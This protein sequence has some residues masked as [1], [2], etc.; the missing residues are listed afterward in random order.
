MITSKSEYTSGALN[1][2]T[3]ADPHSRFVQFDSSCIYDLIIEC[4]NLKDFVAD[5]SLDGL[6]VMNVYKRKQTFKLSWLRQI[7]M[8]PPNWLGGFSSFA[9]TNNVSSNFSARFS[10]FINN[11]RQSFDV[12]NSHTV[13]LEDK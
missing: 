1:N 13:S 2:L 9:A 5:C 4:Y 3:L 6:F 8:Y 7:F 10:I 12:L 11:I